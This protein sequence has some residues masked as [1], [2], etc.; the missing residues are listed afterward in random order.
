MKKRGE[1]EKRR[2]ND[3]NGGKWHYSVPHGSVPSHRDSLEWVSHPQ[4]DRK[5][6]SSWLLLPEFAFLTLEICISIFIF[7]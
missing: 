6:T 5:T 3:G 4:W 7:S 2:R 1:G